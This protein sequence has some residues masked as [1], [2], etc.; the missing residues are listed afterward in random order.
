MSRQ[1]S[2][3]KRVTKP[4]DIFRDEKPTQP[5][6]KTT[7]P[8]KRPA[9][10]AISTL[11]TTSA[12][13]TSTK[14]LPKLTNNVTKRPG[15]AGASNDNIGASNSCPILVKLPFDVLVLVFKHLRHDRFTLWISLTVCKIFKDAV[16][17]NLYEHIVL[18]YLK[19]YPEG[20]NFSALYMLSQPEYEYLRSYVR[21]VDY[22]FVLTEHVRRLHRTPQSSSLMPLSP[23]E[24]PQLSSSAILL[25]PDSSFPSW[26]TGWISMLSTLPNIRSFIFRHPD[27]PNRFL[28]FPNEILDGA[29]S[30]LRDN[31]PQLEEI[32]LLFRVNKQDILRFRRGFS[33]PDDK[34][35]ELDDVSEHKLGDDSRS[36]RRQIGVASITLGLPSG[37]TLPV[38]GPWLKGAREDENFKSLSVL[39][40]YAIDSPNLLKPYI[41][42]LQTLQLGPHHT[43]TN[44]D[45]LNLFIHTPQ[46]RELDIF[47][48]EFLNLETLHSF[49]NI[50]TPELPFLSLLILRHQGV[51]T[52]SQFSSLFTFMD[53][54]TSRS[55]HSL[56]TLSIVSDDQR[57]CAAPSSGGLEKF[58]L[59]TPNMEFL[60]IPHIVLR[61]SALKAVF[62]NLTELRVVSLF[63]VDIKALDFY[64]PRPVTATS[65]LH[66][67]SMTGID[68]ERT[69][70]P[71]TPSSSS[72]ST[73]P[74]V[75]ETQYSSSL[76]G[77]R[78]SMANLTA[79]YLRSNR[80]TCSYASVPDKVKKMMEVLRVGV[81][82][83]KGVGYLR[84]IVS[85][86][87]EDRRQQTWNWR[88]LWTEGPYTD[89]EGVDALKDEGLAM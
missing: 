20:P 86:R 82:R 76:Q 13:K 40:A 77:C 70:C 64:L 60:S 6:K 38:L 45:L 71:G 69:A 11:A 53:V 80:A 56:T 72:L 8:T 59:E 44:I 32:K 83:S 49:S 3:R 36:S 37:D 61:P 65:G 42:G 48:D 2:V 87:A 16:L 55:K 78:I 12:N 30:A 26:T 58:L 74:P 24:I 23:F 47:Y 15:K 14:L 43:L 27:P 66:P 10:K 19:D 29:I 51:S 7:N 67:T 63:L 81:D 73:R 54:L 1:S 75:Q 31:A 62:T 33:G 25:N 34:F 17:P 79:L 5:P 50:P 89:R 41:A 4:P 28:P 22:Q 52:K 46:I 84:K 85:Q 9:P 21:S 18:K 88:A 35:D 57:E 39:D 68:A